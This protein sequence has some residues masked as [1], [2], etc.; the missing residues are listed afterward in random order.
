MFQLIVAKAQLSFSLS[1]QR[2]L[3]KTPLPRP[4]LAKVPTSCRQG[5]FT[6][7]SWLL[8]VNST[9]LALKLAARKVLIIRSS[10]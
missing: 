5:E 2:V 1:S 4:T 9:Q 6:S 3:G 8:K 10:G 7:N